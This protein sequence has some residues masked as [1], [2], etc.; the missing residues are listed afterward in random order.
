MASMN[1]FIGLTEYL[2]KARAG[3]K[4]CKG[5]WN[6]LGS[7]RNEH[8]HVTFLPWPEMSQVVLRGRLSEGRRISAQAID[9]DTGV[10]VELELWETGGTRNK[11]L[12]KGFDLRVFGGRVGGRLKAQTFVKK[13]CAILWTSGPI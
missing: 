1:N 12:G 2:I 4:R 3:K 8:E 13:D 6:G 7:P 5:K 9:L 11:V 10:E